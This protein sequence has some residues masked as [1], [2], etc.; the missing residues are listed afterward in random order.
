MKSKSKKILILILAL[1]LIGSSAVFMSN[2]DLLQGK[3]RSTKKTTKSVKAPKTITVNWEQVRNQNIDFYIFGLQ[4][5]YTTEDNEKIRLNQMFNRTYPYLYWNSNSLHAM[6]SYEHM[7]PLV[8][9]KAKTDVENIKINKIEL[10][11]INTANTEEET[12]I[13]TGL[14]KL[15]EEEGYRHNYY[16]FTEKNWKQINKYI[17]T[18][19]TE[20]NGNIVYQIGF[21][22]KAY[23]SVYKLPP[24][25]KSDKV[26]D[27]V[28][29]SPIYNENLG[30][31]YPCAP[32]DGGVF[33]CND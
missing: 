16:D 23:M 9:A 8:A 28:L 25:K 14:A 11:L 1:A 2:N 17:K 6:L 31:S 10:C 30:K 3:L 7:K 15:I 13:K 4:D 18:Y 32:H 33:E 19:I 5:Y 29:V 22:I 21:N 26:L 27:V 12:C 20:D 24:N